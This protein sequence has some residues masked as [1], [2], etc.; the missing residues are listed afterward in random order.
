MTHKLDQLFLITPFVGASS[1]GAG[2]PAINPGIAYPVCWVGPLEGGGGG[3]GAGGAVVTKYKAWGH[4]PH[5]YPDSD[6]ASPLY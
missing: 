4:S 6:T 2:A 5:N 1:G 3:G